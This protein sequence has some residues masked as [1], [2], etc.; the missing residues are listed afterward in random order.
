[1]KTMVG[2]EISPLPPL[3][4]ELLR[5]ISF[6]HSTISCV[7]GWKNKLSLKSIDITVPLGREI[8]LPNLK[9]HIQNSKNYYW[10][11]TSRGSLTACGAFTT[12]VLYPCW[13]AEPTTA[14]NVAKISLHVAFW[15]TWEYTNIIQ[16]TTCNE[17]EENIFFCRIRLYVMHKFN[18]NIGQYPSYKTYSWQ[19][20]NSWLFYRFN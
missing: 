11:E 3:F 1:M 7:L 5:C 6:N 8:P 16:L 13:K 18:A 17:L 10:T 20:Q 19:N 14:A 4:N 15:N 12:P 2:C 9:V